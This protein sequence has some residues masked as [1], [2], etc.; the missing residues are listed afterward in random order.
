MFVKFACD[1]IGI[2]LPG[3]RAI[4]I[5]ACDEGPESPRDSLS[6]MQRVMDERPSTPLS[7]DDEQELHRQLARRLNLADRFDETRLALGIPLS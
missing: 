1:C 3:G 7:L 4:I 2:P 5:K 6:W